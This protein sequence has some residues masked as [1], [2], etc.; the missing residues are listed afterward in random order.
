[1]TTLR[2]FKIQA[3]I[4][5]L[6]VLFIAC[7]SSRDASQVDSYQAQRQAQLEDVKAGRFDGGKMWTFDYP[8][9]EYFKEAYGFDLTDEW[10]K[11]VR[12]SSLRFA[13]Y[14]SASFVSADG[15]VMTNH[16]CGR[17]A[18]TEVSKEGEDLP[19]VG[20]AAY[21]LEQERQ[22]P[23]LFVEQLNEI[24]D[25][26]PEIHAAMDMATTDE[27]KIA[28]RDS[29]T[30]LIEKTVGE[31]TGMRCQVVSFFNGGK[32]SAYI[33]KRFEDVRLVFSPELE[34]GFFGGDPDNFTYPRYTL[35]CNFFRVYGEDGKPL[36]TDY[37]FPFSD[38]GAL[39]DMPV[40]VTGNPGSTSRLST[41][42]QLEYQRDVYFPYITR[43]LD[44]RVEVMNKYV[45]MHPEVKDEMQND[46]FSMMNS[47]K[48]LRGQY[49]GLLND[50]LMAR[51]RDFDRQFRSSVN[52]DPVL[53][54]KYGKVW[55]QIAQDRALLRSVIK[56]YYLLRPGGLGVS[57]ALSKAHQLV[58]MAQ[59]FMKPE[60]EMNENLRG[61]DPVQTMNMAISAGVDMDM[62]LM[63]LEK[64]LALS[65]DML[66]AS[67]PF[68]TTGLK[69]RTPAQAADA[70]LKNS[71]VT[72][73]VKL[74]ALISKGP[75]GILNS[76]D[77]LIEMAII[78]RPRFENAS[79]VLQS[80]QARDEVNRALLGR[81]QFE[82]YG[83]D[84]P[85]DATFTLRLA[86]GVVKGYEYNGTIAPPITTYFG[87]YNRHYSHIGRDEWDLPDVWKNPPEEFDL[88]TPLNFVSTNDIIG[89]NSGSPVINK[90]REVVG[91]VFDGNIE[92]LP[93]E[94]IFAEDLGNRTVSVHS[95]AMVES[96]KW[97]YKIDRL[98]Y[99]LENGKMPE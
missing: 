12:M 7:S 27:R 46:I 3:L 64:Q 26:T 20:Y 89:G 28:V 86:D 97:I 41:V 96:I 42:A 94:F 53:K 6:P 62:D 60:E 22:V 15:L 34:L 78:A 66:G 40:F 72:D 69:S 93:G 51:R 38:E 85:P 10:L 35:D 67:D 58:A 95:E 24:R 77:P 5:L 70:L 13:T 65:R 19:N 23:G 9:K 76:D 90:E 87:L 4:L 81:A 52:A 84:I 44:D 14:C 8:P 57:S 59:E 1:M 50:V 55:D 18:V 36:K 48:A 75:E 11:H 74:D 71:V 92:S 49:E 37:Y 79:E 82:V 29:L 30:A 63:T 68:V 33:Y 32:F 73:S 83:T 61:K 54:A 31:E 16:H 2:H 80:V 39:P 43:L 25:V 99:E 56:E 17:D 98:A 91:L 45:E 88:S 47:Q 21:T